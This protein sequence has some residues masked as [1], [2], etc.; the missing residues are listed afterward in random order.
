M[1]DRPISYEQL[2]SY[3]AGEV[4]A[5]EAAELEAALR[6]QP[7]LSATVARMRAAIE[8][9]RT[10]DSQAP[11][12]AALERA[13][14]I[15]APRAAGAANWLSDLKQTLATLLFDSRQQPALAGFRGEFD[16]V[17]LAYDCPTMEVEL[18]IEPAVESG[19]EGRVMGQLTPKS[20][21]DLSAEP[22]SGLR[23]LLVAGDTHDV[24]TQCTP[25][26]HGVFELAAPAG[27]YELVIR[28]GDEAIVL[29]D[30]E[31]A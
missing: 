26:E 14:R 3:A 29:P 15:F 10:D 28:S 27:S 4:S 6:G 25:D 9:M 5:A 17:Q 21:G 31:I 11:S 23:L 22:L 1:A 24:L 12:A 30:L 2:L 7:A 13:R 20:A 19:G 8:L 16:R 18:E